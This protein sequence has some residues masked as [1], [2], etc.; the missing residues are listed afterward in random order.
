MNFWPI[1]FLLGAVMPS[2]QGVTHKI[3]I[4]GHRGARA[5]HPENALVSFKY[6]AEL[7]VDYIEMD[8]H[9][10]KDGQLVVTHDPTLSM[11]RCHKGNEPL[12]EKIRIID[13]TYEELK[14]YHCGSV[15]DNRGF[16]QI[17]SPAPI[18]LFK[19]VIREVLAIHPEAQFN[20]EIKYHEKGMEIGLYPERIE[21]VKS[22]LTD[23][24]V[25]GIWEKSVVQSFDRKILLLLKKETKEKL[26]KAQQEFKTLG[27]QIAGSY[28][29]K[30]LRLSFL[31]YGEKRNYDLGLGFCGDFCWVPDWKEAREFMDKH[32]FPI[33]SPAFEKMD[34]WLYSSSYKK[35]F[36][37]KERSFTV[38][39]WTLNKQS[40]WAS[41]VEK[42]KVDGIITDDPKR[43]LEFL[44]P[45]TK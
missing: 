39:P 30:E 18:P 33:F 27:N 26:E 22:L 29:D 31:Y 12:K 6:A 5:I 37:K 14:Q 24:I 35:H 7:K 11:P 40:Q 15:K 25:L 4:H 3:E 1:I 38:V 44:N 16:P 21:L 45:I 34:H 9:M 36:M 23:I 28:I 2:A 13:L 8:L 19:D 41:A 32:Q 20:I 17:T 10:T 43:L 42:F